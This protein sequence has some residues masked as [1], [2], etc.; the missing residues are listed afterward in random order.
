VKT[1]IDITTIS[2][3]VADTAG[4]LMKQGRF[5]APDVVSL[6]RSE[7]PLLVARQERHLADKSIL[8]QAKAWLRQLDIDEDD[9][10]IP[11]LPL[12]LPRAIAVPDVTTGD[13][14]YIASDKATW[15]EL[16]AGLD[17]RRVNKIR[18]EAALKAYE[19]EMERVQ[20]LM[21]V[22][23]TLTYGEACERLA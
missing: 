9:Q 7:Y 1:D 21:E 6:V 13:F 14:Y 3:A 10:D 8:A 20:P 16:L 12:G 22:D 2:Q 5:N 23:P 11:A 19:A 17:Q 15:P 18:A 4:R